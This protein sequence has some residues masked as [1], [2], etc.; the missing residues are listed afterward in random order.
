MRS[1]ITKVSNKGTLKAWGESKLKSDRQGP[2]A[3]MQALI[4]APVSPWQWMSGKAKT[5]PNRLLGTQCIVMV[6]A[7]TSVSIVEPNLSFD[8]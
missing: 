5:G 4:K 6:N 8:S 1:F 2:R 3:P 7:E